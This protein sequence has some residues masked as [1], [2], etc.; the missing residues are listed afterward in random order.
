[1]GLIVQS[2]LLVFHLLAVVSQSTLAHSGRE[3]AKSDLGRRLLLRDLFSA[4]APAAFTFYGV[5]EEDAAPCK[6]VAVIVLCR[7]P[8]IDSHIEQIVSLMYQT[9][10]AK[11]TSSS[12]SPLFPAWYIEISVPPNKTAYC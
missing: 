8:I 12:R 10:G 5:F 11:L 3:R 7:C 4:F 1:M 9:S 6:T 2:D